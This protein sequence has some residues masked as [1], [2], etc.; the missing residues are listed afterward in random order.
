MVVRSELKRV[1]AGRGRRVFEKNEGRQNA[2]EEVK[3]QEWKASMFLYI[4]YILVK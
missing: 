3:R 4:L 1:G 2:V